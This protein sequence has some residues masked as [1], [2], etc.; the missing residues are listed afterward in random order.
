MS[1][2]DCPYCHKP[3]SYNGTKPSGASQYRCRRGCLTPE[4]KTVT[5][6]DSDRKRGGQ[7]MTKVFQE[8]GVTNLDDAL[9]EIIKLKLGYQPWRDRRTDLLSKPVLTDTDRQELADIE[10][11]LMPIGWRAGLGRSHEDIRAAEIIRAAAK[12]MNN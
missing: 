5:M 9:S 4:G 10:A 6:T 1:N 2:P 3:M 8:L 12:L 11:K 7:T